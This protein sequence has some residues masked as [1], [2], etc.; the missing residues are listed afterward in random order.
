MSSAE[1][2]I[3][4]RDEQVFSNPWPPI[5]GGLVA[6]GLAALWLHLMGPTLPLGRAILL[7]LGLLSVGAG[8]SI[9]PKSWAVLG[10]AAAAG[11]LAMQGMNP[12]TEIDRGWD[13]IRLMTGVA[14]TFAAVCA[15]L[16]TLPRWLQRSIVSLL[17]LVHFGGILTAVTSV[18][19]QPWISNAVWTHFYRPYLEFMYLN[20]A[21]HF[22][23]PDPGPATMLWAWV[24]FTD[25]TARWIKLPNKEDFP[26]AVNYQRRLSLTESINQLKPNN[27]L[28]QLYLQQKMAQRVQAARN[29]GIPPH[30]VIDP[31]LQYREPVPFS[32]KM[33]SSYARHIAKTTRHLEDPE[34]LVVSVKMY[35]VVHTI[36]TPKDMLD[37]KNHPLDETTYVPYYQGEFD[38]DGNLMDA[39]NPF[40]YWLIPILREPKR[41][42]PGSGF[43]TPL[44]GEMELNNYLQVHAELQPERPIVITE[45]IKRREQNTP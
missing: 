6:I 20:N 21:Y 38:I 11:F 39:D 25:G 30:P 17:I 41:V 36:M 24:R 7:S 8:I 15:I 2:Q 31:N 14:A 43:S 10:T 29:T 16:V 5:V 35:R 32:K 12:P 33:L 18:P 23:S 9:R 26:M 19:P 42:A 3:E 13:S 4:P 40:L 44:T 28:G 45:P 27:A 1:L 34:Q 22:Y 37:P